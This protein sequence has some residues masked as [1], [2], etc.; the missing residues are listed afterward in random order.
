MQLTICPTKEPRRLG[1][2]PVQAM[3][4]KGKQER[5]GGRERDREEWRGNH[6]RG[7]FSIHQRV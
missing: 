1:S 7:M 4:G 5:A 2:T 6:A 3:T